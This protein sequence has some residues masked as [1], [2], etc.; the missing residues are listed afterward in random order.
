VQTFR[1]FYATVAEELPAL[2]PT[3]L[4]DYQVS[5]M[6]R[7]FKVFYED[8]SQH[9]ELWFRDG[10]LEVA[11]HMEGHEEDDEPVRR[12]LESKLATIRKRLGGDVRLEPFGRG[13]THLYELWPGESRGADLAREAAERL[14]EFVRLLEPMRRA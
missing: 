2:L 9:F 4:R 10:G 11:L 5:R 12:L 7:V 1:D 6:G 14:A 8:R 13:W 3:D